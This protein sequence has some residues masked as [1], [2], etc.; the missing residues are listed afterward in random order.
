M[1]YFI[2]SDLHSFKSEFEKALKKKGLSIVDLKELE[3][4]EKQRIYRYLIN[5]GFSGSCINM[6]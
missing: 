6:Y 3:P 5:K 2:V 1:K 4:I